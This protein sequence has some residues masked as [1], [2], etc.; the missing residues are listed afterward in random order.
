M[1]RGGPRIEKLW[2]NYSAADIAISGYEGLHFT[3]RQRI[4]RKAARWTDNYRDMPLLERRA[5]LSAM[6]AVED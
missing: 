2:M 5:V 6:L 3:D 1:T 4:K